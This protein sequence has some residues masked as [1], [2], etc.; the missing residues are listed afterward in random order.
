MQT[1]N[2]IFYRELARFC[3]VAW[4]V[5]VLYQKQW[6]RFIVEVINQCLRLILTIGLAALTTPW[7]NICA[8][9]SERL[10]VMYRGS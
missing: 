7:G 10:S 4:G 5:Y 8:A 6:V 9:I 1:V 2:I 3:L